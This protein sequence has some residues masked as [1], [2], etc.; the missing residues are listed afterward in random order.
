MVNPTRIPAAAAA[1]TVAAHVP[2]SPMMMPPDADAAVAVAVAV[3]VELG[4]LLLQMPQLVAGRHCAANVLPR[5]LR[6]TQ[7]TTTTR[8][9]TTGTALQ[10]S[11]ERVL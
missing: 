5:C 8:A 7:T 9:T 10:R 6:S 3:E 1:T 2:Q 11:S 4:Q